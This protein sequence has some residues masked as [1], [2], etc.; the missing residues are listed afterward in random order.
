MN[1]K[2]ILFYI[3]GFLFLYLEPIELVAGFT[4]GI[5]WKLVLLLIL[6]FPILYRVLRVKK[7]ELFA[8]FSI[9][10]AFKI[11]I[12]YSSL[13]YFTNTITLF[14]KEMMFPM[15]FL[16]FSQKIKDESTLYFLIRHFSI[17]I[18]LSFLPYM[19]GILEPFSLGYALA[20]FGH[21]GEYGLI[22]PFIKPH[23]ASVM[24]SFAMIVI[25]TSI[26]KENSLSLNLFYVALLALG[27][28]ELIAMYVRTGIAIYIA[29]L[30]YL[31]LREISLKKI[32]LLMLT[33]AVLVGA[34][35][36]LYQTNDIVQMRIDDKN[37]Y[38]KDTSHG[39]GGSGRFLF[40]KNAIDNW[41]DDEPIVIYIGLG[42]EYA[43]EKMYED[44]GLHIFAHNHFIQML[45]QEGIIGFL[46]FITYMF[47][48]YQ[49]IQRYKESD[50]FVA[51]SALFLGIIIEMLFQGG[52]FFPPV[53][54][55]SASLVIL[56][57][58]ALK[59]KKI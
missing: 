23:S 56:K 31:Y 35:A 27:F 3:I 22:G 20:E 19:F 57:L 16:F 1:L 8:L 51:T 42:E 44:V 46:F 48:I 13:D 55:L 58:N 14:T 37:K 4:F 15:L 50:Y 12:S 59:N 2:I 26:R 7:I 11:L 38:S 36:Y 49:Y 9:L 43:K 53:L 30:I 6:F 47:L 17:V 28:Y 45:Q 5:I 52:F 41:L 39:S 25:T 29:V 32:L 54:F 18:I 40:W 34:V 33:S 10:L 21:E 24:T